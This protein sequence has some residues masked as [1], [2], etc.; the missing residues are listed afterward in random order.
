VIQNY[1]AAL[2]SETLPPE[3]RAAYIKTIL[4]ATQKMAALV[5]GILKLNKLE[6]QNILPKKSNFDLGEH[7]RRS[8]LAFEELWESKNITFEADLDEVQVFSNENM[9]EIVWNNLLSNAIKFTNPGGSIFLSLKT[10]DNDPVKNKLALVTVRDSGCGMD[11]QTQKHIFDKF[12]Q[13][14]SSHA[15]EGNG[16]GLALAKKTLDL[17]GGTISVESKPGKGSM[18]TVK[19]EA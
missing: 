12:Y 3:E 14:D 6:N 18:F 1:A 11:E 8:A 13:G 15:T 9:L 19:L 17:L 4:E 2:Q 7:I 16:L 10:L 5:T